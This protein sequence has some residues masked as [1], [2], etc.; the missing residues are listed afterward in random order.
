ML[1]LM[2]CGRAVRAVE[3]L[4][5]GP[6]FNPYPERQLDFVL[7]SPKFSSLVMLVIKIAN[8]FASGQLGF[9]TLGATMKTTGLRESYVTPMKSVFLKAQSGS[10]KSALFTKSSV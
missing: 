10:K 5:G 2:Q 3:L 1:K 9:L 4:S 8:W 7:G 6:E